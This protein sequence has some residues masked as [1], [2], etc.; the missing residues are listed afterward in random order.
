MIRLANR[1][2]YPDG[3]LRTA[4]T[5]IVRAGHLIQGIQIENERGEISQKYHRNK[6]YFSY[7]STHT[8][9]SGSLLLVFVSPFKISVVFSLMLVSRTDFGSLILVSSFFPTTLFG[10]RDFASQG[11]LEFLISSV[12]PLTLRATFSITMFVLSSSFEA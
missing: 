9:Y 10:L 8:A 6:K 3:V 2:E 12:R 5:S 7:L 11:S 1:C 4:E